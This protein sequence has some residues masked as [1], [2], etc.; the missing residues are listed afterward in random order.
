MSHTRAHKILI[1]LLFFEKENKSQP[2]AEE[3]PFSWLT[4]EQQKHADRME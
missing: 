3:K 2:A 4:N 1:L